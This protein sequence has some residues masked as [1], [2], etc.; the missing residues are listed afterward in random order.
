MV[1]K[2]ILLAFLLLTVSCGGAD[3]ISNSP[4]I[5]LPNNLMRVSVDSG[6]SGNSINQ[7]F[8]TV[9]ICSIEIDSQCQTI[10]HIIIDTGSTGLRLLS[11]AISPNIKL[12]SQVDIENLPLFNCVQ[13]LDGSYAWGPV[14][15]SN[16][17][18]G[19]KKAINVPLQVIGDQNYSDLDSQCSYY[20]TLNE[21][22]SVT[23][24]GGNGIL[25]L[26]VFK[27]DCGK[28]CNTN[29][30]NGIYFKCINATCSAVMETAV[31]QDLQIKN[32]ITLFTL[33]NNGFV[34]D[35]PPARENGQLSLNGNVI[36]GIDTQS[37]NLSK[38]N[39]VLTT[40]SYGYIS[41]LFAGNTLRYSFI[42]TGSNGLYFDYNE[43]R[44]CAD[45][46]V[47]PSFYCPDGLTSL[48][49]ILV[50]ANGVSSPISFTVANA[51][52]L[53][54]DALFS[55]LPALAGSIGNTDVFVWGLP[56]FYGRQVFIGLEEEVSDLGIGP[57]FA[58]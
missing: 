19:E 14:K 42:D 41:T 44:T 56:F 4:E 55:V 53:I 24:L 13:F 1:L 51:S 54:G 3:K 5:L 48:S 47:G 27:E 46:R 39:S 29:E 38:Y 2:L 22:N 37:N 26:S 30:F 28:A 8:T 36:F 58:F 57:L 49:A 16:V 9:I 11:S 50:G 17:F 45:G 52:L 40:D 33:D 12:T 23:S 21:I 15:I 32:P 34:I 25:G 43:I 18:F 20:G 6:L 31:R 35:L 7:M 10:D